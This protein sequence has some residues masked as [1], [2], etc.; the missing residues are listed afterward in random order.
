MDHITEIIDEKYQAHLQDYEEGLIRDFSDALIAAK[1]EALAQGKE[2]APY[3][4]DR[5][6]IYALFDL[7][8]GMT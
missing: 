4:K 8:M 3:L 7:F 6:L 1:Q 5:N 2:S